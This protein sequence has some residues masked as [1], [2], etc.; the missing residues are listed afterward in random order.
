MTD[1][2]LVLT[3]TKLYNIFINNNSDEY[4]ITN[5]DLH[6]LNTFFAISIQ[7]IFTG[8]ILDRFEQL[9]FDNTIGDITG[10]IT[11]PLERYT[12]KNMCVALS[13]MD[14]LYYSKTNEYIQLYK[15]YIID[16]VAQLTDDYDYDIIIQH[17]K[18]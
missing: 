13:Q 5:V 12:F 18:N 2:E 9:T 3:Y 11:Q 15:N 10:M 14:N 7:L 8:I 17:L 6:H 4:I 1:S 16:M